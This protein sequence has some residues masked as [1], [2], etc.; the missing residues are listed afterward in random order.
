MPKALIGLLKPLQRI[1]PWTRELRF[2]PSISTPLLAAVAMIS[3]STR[4]RKEKNVNNG[5]RM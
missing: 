2:V 1:P 3:G 5:K 4:R